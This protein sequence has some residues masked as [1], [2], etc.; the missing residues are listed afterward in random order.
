[1]YSLSAFF[2]AWPLFKD[3]V[4]TSVIA[5]AALG[6]AGGYIH[7]RRYIFLTAAVSQVAGLGV[8]LSMWVAHLVGIASLSELAPLWSALMSLGALALFWRHDLSAEVSRGGPHLQGDQELGVIYLVGLSGT[9]MIGA[10]ITHELSDIQALLFGS[11]VAVT[12]EGFWRVM[13]VGVAFG[14]LHLW[15]GRGLITM[16]IDPVGAQLRGLPVK[17]L[18]YSLLIGLG[19]L[20][21]VSTQTLGALP[22]FAASVLPTL[23]V[24]PWCAQPRAIFL[25]GALVGGLC[26]FGGYL[27]AFLSDSPVGASQSVSAVSLYVLSY[28]AARIARA[29]TR[30]ASIESRG[31]AP[32][33]QTGSS[34][35]AE[36]SP[37][38]E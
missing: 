6:L 4:I 13:T 26:G 36:E 14:L 27:F 10:H 32:L 1:M 3:P 5:W 15:W 16:T 34:F 22:V 30:R 29:V 7:A 33:N 25:A 9:L 35:K 11:A 18:D 31:S 21:S 19:L 24:R 28:L 37:A 17:L 38:E 2:E 8:A 23:I 20:I 12:E